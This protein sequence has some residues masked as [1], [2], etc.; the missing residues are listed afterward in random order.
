MFQSYWQKVAADERVK[1]IGTG[2]LIGGAAGTVVSLFRL[3]IS[4]LLG[5]VLEIYAFLRLH[6][7]GLWGWI[8]L[9]ILAAVLVGLLVKSEPNIKGSGIPQV[10]GQVLGLLHMDWWPVLWKKFVGGLLASGAGLFLGREGPSIQLGAMIGQGVSQLTKGD[11]VQEK[12]LLSSGAGAGLAAAFNAPLAGLMFVL[13]EVHHN[14]S[15]LVAL[16]TLT[17]AVTSNFVSLNI[18]GLKPALDIGAMTP[19]PMKYYGHAILLG[20]LLGIFGFLYTKTTL[21]LPALFAKIPVLPTHFHSILAFLLI[22]PVGYFLPMTLGGGGEVVMHL[23]KWQLSAGFLLLLFVLR[24]LYSMF[25]YGAG[26]PGGIFLPV[27]S[28]GAILGG[29]FIQSFIQTGGVEPQYFSHFLIFSMAGYFTAVG[30]APLTAILL[31][32]EMVGGMSQLMPVSLTCLAAYIV[33]DFLGGEP[34]YEALLERLAAPHEVSYRGKRLVFDF[35]VEVNSNLAGKAIREI[36]WPDSMLVTSIRRGQYTYVARGKTIL[37][38]GDVLVVITDIGFAKAVQE[39]LK[40]IAY[41]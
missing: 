20:I 24:F 36:R 30:K 12:I 15:T 34:I 32:T 3:G 35:P 6:P 41:P 28:L 11:D 38:P 31:V 21:A 17:A 8:L 9:S 25:S 18:F 19:L 7:E 2:L 22:I 26:L 27:L 14:F 40:K 1:Y 4:V 23:E 37:Q 10:E 33:S 39:G 16:S 29:A 5:K 13:E